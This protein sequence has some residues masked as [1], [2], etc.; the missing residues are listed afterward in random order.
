MGLIM[1]NGEFVGRD[2]IARVNTPQGTAS[3]KP[4]PHIDVID[5]VT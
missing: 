3:W 4:V 5:A 2:E 1:Q